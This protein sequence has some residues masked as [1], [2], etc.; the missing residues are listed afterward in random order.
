MENKN[1]SNTEPATR[2]TA[3]IPQSAIRNPHSD[4]PQSNEI[5]IVEDSPVEAEILRRT[6]VRAGYRVVLAK[7]GEEGLQALREHHCTL[8]MSDINMPLMSGYELCRT[9]KFD[10]NLWSTPV[11]LVTTLSEPKDIIMALDVGA[12]SYITK[13]YVEDILLGRIRSLLTNPSRRK[14]AE[15][16]R[17]I[18]VE[19]GG[20]KHNVAVDSPQMVNLLLSVYENSL[21]LNQEL[22]HIQNQLSLLNGSL[23]EKVR[24]RTAALKESE[25]KFRKI[26]GSAQDAI[27]MMDADQ[28]VSFWNAAATRIFGYT[29]AEAMGQELH[30]LIAPAPARAVFTQAFPH[31]QESGDG[32]IIGKVRELTALRKG[33]EE[34]PVEM[35]VSATQLNGQWCAIGIV[36]DITER[37]RT[38]ILLNKQL[39]ELRRWHEATLGVG[40]RAIELKREVNELLVQAGQPP[41][42]P[43]AEQSDAAAE[44]S[45]RS[46]GE[47]TSAPLAGE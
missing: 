8:V 38:E 16:R 31:F 25:E 9:I 29:A 17:K 41:R 1:E 39:G 35:S 43:S 45:L 47:P 42:Y 40:M 24:E 30:A 5:L 2:S 26:T 33:G 19:Y 3:S 22:M 20:E 27:I 10:E 46:S 37:K 44:G 36:R 32:P 7:N 34:F 6:L 15:E 13:P 18:Q 11:I 21:T 4:I 14:L 12:D 28:R 23:D